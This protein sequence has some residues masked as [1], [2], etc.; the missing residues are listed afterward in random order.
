MRKKIQQQKGCG[1][2][3]QMHFDEN[4]FL[5]KKDKLMH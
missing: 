2:E 1:E 3:L 4:K 5:K